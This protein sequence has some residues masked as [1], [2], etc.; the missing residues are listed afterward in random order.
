MQAR[1]CN[2]MGFPSFINNIRFSLA[3]GI[4]FTPSCYLA[5]STHTIVEHHNDEYI[6]TCLPHART[7]LTLLSDSH[8]QSHVWYNAQH[9]CMPMPCVQPHAL[10]HLHHAPP[11]ACAQLI[12]LYTIMSKIILTKIGPRQGVFLGLCT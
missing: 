11:G 2:E 9:T 12:H 4:I 8:A 3:N 5:S 1:S 10:T 6:C 7:H